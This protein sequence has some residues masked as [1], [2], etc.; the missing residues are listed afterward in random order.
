MEDVRTGLLFLEK[1]DK[2]EACVTDFTDE[3]IK[4]ILI[5]A[6][7]ESVSEYWPNLAL[8]VLE[9]HKNYMNEQVITALED[10]SRSKWASQNF[11]HRVKKLL[12]N[13]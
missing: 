2:Y 9:N 6:F 13:G 8:K 7:Q 10:A 11:R 5:F 12:K 4:Q 1:I 3:D